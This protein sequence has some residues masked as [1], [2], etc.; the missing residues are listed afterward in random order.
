AKPKKILQ[1]KQL[2]D[3]DSDQPLFKTLRAGETVEAQWTADDKWY[4]ARVVQ[5][6]HT[7]FEIARYK[8]RYMEYGN[9]ET[10]SWT[11]I[12]RLTGA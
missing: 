8:V 1:D 5:S 3:D 6:I 11:R 2:R 12:R 7:G 9:E 4:N 10:I